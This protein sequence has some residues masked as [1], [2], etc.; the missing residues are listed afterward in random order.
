[1]APRQEP[2]LDRLVLL[3]RLTL[4]AERLAQGFW[5]TA[6]LLLAALAL[7]V[8]GLL[9]MAGGWLHLAALALLGGAF[10]AFLARGV[11]V[12]RL[13]SG[14][15]ARTRLD[16]QAE[17]Q[18]CSTLADRPA[19]GADDSFALAAWGIHRRRALQEARGLQPQ[20]P[21]FA[22]ARRDP[23][24]LRA[25][26][27][28]LL[29]AALVYSG[30]DWAPRLGQSLKPDL[31]QQ[32][33]GASV[34]VSVEA[35]I[36]PPAYTGVAPIYLTQGA[37][38]ALD[39]PLPGGSTLEIR[40]F[41]ARSPPELVSVSEA[42]SPRVK[43][44]T[45]F[46][47]QSH[48]VVWQLELDSRVSLRANGRETAA[49]NFLVRP[50]TPP[51]IAFTALPAAARS[52]ALSFAYRVRDDY[53]AAR[54]WAVIEAA[55]SLDERLLR[56][57]PIELSLAVPFGRVT[58]SEEFAIRDLTAHPWAGSDAYI[59][60]WVEDDAGQTGSTERIAFQLP[61]RSFEEPMAASFAEQRLSLAVGRDAGDAAET[62]D[63]MDAL[64]RRPHEYF[65]DKVPYLAARV[66]ANRIDG[67]IGD[68]FE[69]G[70]MD[71]VLALLWSATLRLEEGE[72]AEAQERLRDA[73]TEL[74][75]ALAENA[76]ESE[77]A[78]LMQELRQAIAE[79]LREAVNQEGQMA[80]GEAIDDGALDQL[81]EEL[82]R[83]AALGQ[84]EAARRML[85][86]LEG[87]L[88][89]LQATGQ[90]RMP[91][92]SELSSLIREQMELADE[93][94]RL[95]EQGGQGQTMSLEELQRRQQEL[96]DRL[97]E[98]AEQF[99]EQSG[100]AGA[101]IME[102]FGQAGEAMER[103]L[104]ALG[105]GQAGEALGPQMEAAQ[106]LRGAQ[107]EWMQQQMGQGVA[108][109][110][111]GNGDGFQT[112]PLGRMMRGRN[113][114]GDVEVIGSEGGYSAR[115]LY[116]EI[117][118]RAGDRTRQRDEREYL[119]RLIDRF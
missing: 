73:I 18:P 108:A 15:E 96:M 94:Q 104:G 3:S 11:R 41:G 52:N 69:K 44:F 32:A 93:T 24:A 81:L 20:P 37:S 99:G 2:K 75:D 51:E 38:V 66:A 84:R 80:E 7:G 23:W 53:G 34:E 107:L 70:E 22:L 6:S 58:E 112:D 42:G 88:E 82:Q 114:F 47:K 59:T 30:S 78:R 49:W 19:I 89:N 77:I 5:P 39:E 14:R 35:W 36:E 43:S 87:L 103:A 118:R 90:L 72:F 1:M 8:S 4:A 113:P 102:R 10:L 25:A 67:M 109:G 100:E 13:P 110:V 117:R 16:R 92:D 46:G 119:E 65:E 17:T 106:T 68:G 28:L 21:D 86:Q 27:I 111:Q 12:W 64:I 31:S 50:D 74:E 57:D 91:Q 116:E 60:L 98:L 76:P 115:Q 63:I 105:Q 40:T 101:A 95:Q 71:G 83:D 97:A 56:L 62:L 26:S 48:G 54:A 9:P 55:G 79:Y 29:A 85:S 45:T 61:Q 33:W